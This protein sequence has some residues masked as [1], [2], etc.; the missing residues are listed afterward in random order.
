MLRQTEEPGPETAERASP[1]PRELSIVEPRRRGIRERLRELWSYRG[2]FK[3]FGGRA[4]DK[5]TARTVI[6]RPWLILRPAPDVLTVTL[7]F[8]GLLKVPSSQP[9]VLPV[10]CGGRASW[11]A[12]E[13]SV[14]WSTRSLELNRKLL[15]KVDFP[16]LILPVAS[17]SPA[18][19][20]LSIYVVLLLGGV[21]YYGIVDGAFYLEL[22]PQLL[23]AVAALVLG[24]GLALAIGVWTSVLGASARDVR[25]SLTYALGF[26]LS[27]HG[28]LPLSLVPDKYQTLAAANP[29]TPVVELF[30]W[31]CSTPERRCRSGS[32]TPPW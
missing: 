13:T 22:G 5:M 23:A 16:R 31:G 12:F 11:A 19:V 30:K 24:I 27:D 18:I 26:W 7:I 8:G 25:F 9:A 6:G 10:L 32:P 28:V 21:A 17:I 29:I 4:L 15:A 14:I 20:E 3:F 2:L 1:P